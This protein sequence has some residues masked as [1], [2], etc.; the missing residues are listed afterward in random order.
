MKPERVVLFR[1]RTVL[2][3]AGVL[4]G[5]ACAL[6]IVW[7]ARQVIT[8]ILVAAFLA[9]ALNPAVALLQR[10]GLR[11]RLA[12]AAVI[13]LFA[14]LVLAGIGWLLVPPL[15][16]QVS[17][18]GR[19]A[20]GYVHQLTAGKGPLGFLERDYH[21]VEKARQAVSNQ[22]GSGGGASK[23]LGGASTVVSLT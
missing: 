19:A 5:V 2:Q 12:A 4:L 3:V 13:Y 21:V 22:G 17:G 20:P 11:Q 6:W 7:V 16:D 14:L 23:L 1:P 9:L 18:F 8:W 15:V 10:R